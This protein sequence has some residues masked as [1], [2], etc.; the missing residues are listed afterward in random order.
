MTDEQQEPK[1]APKPKP[2]ASRPVKIDYTNRPLEYNEA[3]KALKEKLN[4]PS[5]GDRR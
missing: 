4:H 3:L 5:N 1:A 2:S